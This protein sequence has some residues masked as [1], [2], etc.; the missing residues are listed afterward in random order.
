M[1]IRPIRTDADHKA[2]LA[3][4]ERL[5]NAQPGSV[6]ESELDALA[7]LVEAYEE[8]RWPIPPVKPVEVLKFVMDQNDRSQADLGRLLGSRSRASEIMSG[9]RDLSLD[10]IRLLTRR[11]RIPAAALIGELEAV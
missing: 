6:E 5:W 10:Q 4:I 11:W 3:D 7:T 8:R 9:K 1:E 2:A